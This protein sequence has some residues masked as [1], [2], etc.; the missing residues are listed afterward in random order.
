MITLHHASMSRS[1]R[2]LWLL[3]ELSA[4]YEIKRISILRPDGSG[5][6]DPANPHPMRQVPVIEDDGVVI[7]ET[8][9]IMLHL[10]DKFANAGL[11]PPPD[12]AKRSAYMG[13]LGQCIGLL[14]PML[15]ALALKQ[16]LSERQEAARAV[17]A[18]NLASALDR[19]TYLLGTDFSTADLAWFSY[20]RLAPDFLGQIPGLAE[21]VERINARPALAKA[22]SLD[23]DPSEQGNFG[24]T[25][26]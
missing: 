1:T 17:L 7:N 24:S 13:W 25:R 18:R 12:H 21:W 10:T 15:T 11:A 9:L 26:N 14:D 2:I 6:P 22:R 20:L 16:P 4:P 3:E 8:I 5:G 19:N 23:S